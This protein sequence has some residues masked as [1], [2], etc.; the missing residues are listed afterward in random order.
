MPPPP[1]LRMT[2]D[3]L[4]S[5]P[6]E[7][8]L[9]RDAGV[10]RFGVKAAYMGSAASAG[11]EEPRSLDKQT[12]GW[13]SRSSAEG[14]ADGSRCEAVMWWRQRPVCGRDNNSIVEIA[15]MKHVLTDVIPVIAGP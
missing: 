6:P 13:R 9:R 15:V 1:P 12:K 3:N 5:D 10:W 11:M 2:P 8:E 14:R 4:A 7:E